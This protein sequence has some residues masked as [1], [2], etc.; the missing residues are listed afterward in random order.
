MTEPPASRWSSSRVAVP[1][2]KWMTGTDGSS[3]A[4]SLAMCGCTN[5]AIVVRAERANPAIEDLKRL[6]PA[7]A[8]AFK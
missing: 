2:P 3:R 1:V 4:K 7:S 8:C 6:R 5:R